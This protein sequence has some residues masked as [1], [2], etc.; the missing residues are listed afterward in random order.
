M[1]QAMNYPDIATFVEVESSGY[2]NAKV[3]LQQFDVNVMFVQ[4]TNLIHANQR[5]GI[6]AD[7]LCYP[8][9]EN[10]FIVALANRLEGLYVKI[11]LFNSAESISWFKISKCTISRDHLLSNSIDNIELQL[12]KC[13]PVPGVS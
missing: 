10:E 12:K 1:T 3:M 7:A 5:D 8:D 2:A 6:D 13:E 11:P 4:S 9:F